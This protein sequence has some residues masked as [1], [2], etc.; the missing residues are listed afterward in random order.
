MNK[1]K[2]GI[3]DNAYA[4]LTFLAGLTG[5]LGVAILTGVAFFMNESDWLK[6]TTFKALVFV[7]LMSALGGIIS[8]LNDGVSFFVNFVRL[9]DA[10]FNFIIPNNI[11]S[12][13]KIAV[14]FFTNLGLLVFAAKAYKG[15]YIKIAKVEEFTN[16]SL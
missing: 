3:S 9:F 14:S 8:V 12:L 11:I 16:N 15:R 1:T 4:C 2:L 13:L 7:L 5:F 6:K 10:G